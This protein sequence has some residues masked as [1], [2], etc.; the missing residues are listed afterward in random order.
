[1]G[2]STLM[3]AVGAGNGSYAALDVDPEE[4]IDF[5]SSITPAWIKPFLDAH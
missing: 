3:I 1:V 5:A 4:A 2:L